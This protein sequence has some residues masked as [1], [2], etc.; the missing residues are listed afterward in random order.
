MDGRKQGREEEREERGGKEGRK[1]RMEGGEAGENGTVV[2][3]EHLL[4]A[5][6][7]ARHFYGHS[8]MHCSQRPAT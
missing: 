5:R 4:C 3:N 6:N 8:P 7:C 1:D 2:W